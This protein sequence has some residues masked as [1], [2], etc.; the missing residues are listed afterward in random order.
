MKTNVTKTVHTFT[1]RYTDAESQ[2][3]KTSKLSID[4]GVYNLL[5]HNEGYLLEDVKR[6]N[7]VRGKTSTQTDW[8]L[9]A[10]TRRY[11]EENPSAAL[12]GCIRELVF[13]KLIDPSFLDGYV[14][15]SDYIKV[16]LKKDDNSNTAVRLPSSLYFA[17][18]SMYEDACDDLIQ[19]EYT[20][21]RKEIDENETNYSYKLRHNL[22]KLVADP[23]VEID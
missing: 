9:Y 10:E 18:K 22:L 13:C 3:D 17:V 7:V 20:K 14:I 2:K 12:T 1:Y 4:I 11:R 6:P 19:A 15:N 8:W 16:M 5:K 23:L 21:V